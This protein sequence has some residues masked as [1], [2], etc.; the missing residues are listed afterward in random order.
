MKDKKERL[1]VFSKIDLYPVTDSSQSLGRSNYDVLEGLIAGGAGIVQL[2]DKNSNK[3][4]LHLMARRFRERTEQAGML[5][6]INDHIDI[7]L[8]VG[9]DGV[10]LG[11]DDLPL[12]A[13]RAIAPDLLIGIST[14]SLEQ[15][16]EAQQGGADYINIGPI[17]PTGTKETPMAPLGP[18]AIS[19]IRPHL[20]IPF[21]VMGGINRGNIA[22]VL[23]AGA[24]RVA[25]VTA[26]TKARDVAEEV[27]HLRRLIGPAGRSG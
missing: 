3:K 26:V 11:Q 2:R 20:A 16:L 10:H 9:A 17:F 18:E 19:G 8:A 23:E 14:H 1:E 7:A 21:T 15:A 12:D 22:L 5:L 13:A 6:I 27:R 25:V 24:R 4:E